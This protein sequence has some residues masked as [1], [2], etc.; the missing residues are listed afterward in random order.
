M[1]KRWVG[2]S[3]AYFL[4]SR[5]SREPSLQPKPEK[6]ETS[7]AMLEIPGKKCVRE[8]LAAHLAAHLAFF[9]GS[10]L[11]REPSLQPEAEKVETSIAMVESNY[12]EEDII[13]E[14]T[15]VVISPSRI[16]QKDRIGK[17]DIERG[18][19][20]LILSTSYVRKLWRSF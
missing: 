19:A 4:G 17:G 7:I 14:I 11:S 1:C 12:W 15:G 20:D 2:R 9:L 5:L 10:R 8:G 18:D 13:T 16:E 3:L 6:I